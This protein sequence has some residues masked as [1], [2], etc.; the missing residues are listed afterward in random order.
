MPG[1]AGPRR[2]GTLAIAMDPLEILVPRIADAV[3]RAFPPRAPALLL[4]LERRLPPGAWIVS[5]WR[6]G[7]RAKATGASVS[8]DA[9]CA[10][11]ARALRSADPERAEEAVRSL[12]T[13]LR[14][15]CVPAL[16]AHLARWRLGDQPVSR[17]RDWGA[18]AL[19]NGWDGPSLRILAGLGDDELDYWTFRRHFDR[20]LSELGIAVPD[21]PT[22]LAAW[23]REEAR[24][25][26]VGLR[27]PGE[28]LRILDDLNRYTWVPDAWAPALRIADYAGWDADDPYHPD[29]G[30]DPSVVVREA[31]IAALR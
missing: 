13:A 25:L 26:V 2:R 10:E 18:D 22:C 11:A 15:A 27:T 14:S 30:T 1:V 6:E 19:E 28:L 29:P 16:Q 7:E 9:L 17:L 23:L 3:R 12:E 4:A 21:D 24:D 20:A 31:A 5:F 8:R